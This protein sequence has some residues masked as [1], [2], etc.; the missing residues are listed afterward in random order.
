[1]Y[2][3]NKKSPNWYCKHHQDIYT[4]LGFDYH[5]K[6]FEKTI[7]PVILGNRINRAIL[8]RVE[9]MITYLIDAVKQIRLQY[10]FSLDKNSKDLN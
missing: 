7:S 4:E 2:Y 3:P 1:M 9:P 6:I 10:M 8:S 5:G